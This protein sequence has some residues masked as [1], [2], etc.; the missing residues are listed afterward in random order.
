MDINRSVPE[1]SVPSVSSRVKVLNNES[2]VSL[3][4]CGF[5]VEPQYYIQGIAGSY[6]DCYVRETLVDMLL[7]AE[8]LL[9]DGLRFK[10]YDA[11]R[12][13]CVQQRLWNFYRGQVSLNN[14]SLSETEIDYKTSF[15]V[16]KPS[17]DVYEPSLHNTGGAV[18]LTI[19][20]KDGYA[21]N[22][23]T[24]FD[25]FTDR[26]WTNHFEKYSEF[27]EVRKNRRLLYNVML[28]V[29]FTNLPSEW[30]HYDFGDKFWAYFT[31]NE[32]LYSGIIDA[33]LP[34]RFPLT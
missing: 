1:I 15:F 23:G 4:E 13:I 26:A 34:N 7:K 10:I 25:D 17:Y 6:K 11:Y 9:P 5:L 30:W 3:R 31:G 19:V 16:S 12:P 24:L 28:E 27:E 8:S 14:P 2:L 18:D 32:P 22:M 20:T 21:L 33:D 29:G